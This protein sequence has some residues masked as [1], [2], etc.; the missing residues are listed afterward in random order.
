MNNSQRTDRD[1]H[2]AAQVSAEWAHSNK[3]QFQQKLSSLD[4]AFSSA[5]DEMKKVR[6]FVGTPE[7]ILGNPS[8]KHGEIAEQVHVGVTRA[9]DVL[10]GRLPSATFERIG[11]LDPVDYKV[12]GVDIQS[13]YLNG[14]RNT[15]SSI[16]SHVKNNPDFISGNSQYHVPRDQFEQIEQLQSTDVIDGL[17]DRTVKFIQRELEELNRISGRKTEDLI[18]PGNASYDEVQQGNIHETLNSRE[19][20]LVESKE[21]Q[22][23]DIQTK[24]E[25]SIQGLGQAATLAAA[26]GGGVRITQTLWEKW[27]SGKNPF[28]GDFTASDWKDIGLEGLQGAGD[29]AIAGG[30]LYLLTNATDLAAPFAGSTVSA[31]MGIGALLRQYHEGKICDEDFVSLSLLVASEAAIIGL[32]TAVG[33]TLIPVPLL[34]AFVGSIAGKLVTSALK[35]SLE[36]LE[37]SLI[38]RLQEY[39]AKFFE[40]IE[41]QYRSMIDQVDQYFEDLGLILQRS[42]DE[43]LNMS[44]R[45]EASVVLARKLGVSETQVI[46]TVDELDQFMMR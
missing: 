28:Q 7:S 42:L 17:S 20:Q 26:V 3:E 12:D 40:G 45:F 10:S 25:P 11:R 24:H 39:E 22:K 32:A 38:N 34:G 35:G 9:W 23:T 46:C 30:A 29:G 14:L 5:M 13:K 18:Q 27:Q 41:R 1:S 33:Q 31:L 43:T 2:I 44:I 8:T 15:L 4:D 36:N 21:A 19:E 6:D 37:Q 16:R